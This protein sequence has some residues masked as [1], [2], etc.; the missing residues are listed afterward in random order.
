M[1]VADDNLM[2]RVRSDG[3]TF[4]MGIKEPQVPASAVLSNFPQDAL[5]NPFELA[6]EW[7]P[8]NATITE[9]V[10]TAP[11][12]ITAVLFDYGTSG[13]ASVIWPGST[14]ANE[15][16]F[17]NNNLA[18]AV[19]V[20]SVLAAPTSTT[21]GEIA[22]DS[23]ATGPAWITLATPETVE[24][25]QVYLIG[26]AGSEYVAIEAVQSNAGATL[27]RVSTVHTHAPG[28]TLTGEAAYRML[29]PNGAAAGNTLSDG[30]IQLGVSGAGQPIQFVGDVVVKFYMHDHAFAGQC[31][32]RNPVDGGNNPGT[33]GYPQLATAT[34]NSILFNPIEYNG[35]PDPDVQPIEWAT[36]AGDGTITGYT[37][38]WSGATQN[39]NMIVLASIVIPAAGTY[40][41]SFRHDDGMY[42]GMDGDYVVLSGP[43]NC[44]APFPTVSA[45]NGYP[46]VGASNVSN[47]NV[48]TWDIQFNAAGVY[49]IE[50]DYCQWENEQELGIFINGQTV[51]PGGSSTPQYGMY[52]FRQAY[53]SLMGNRQIQPTDVVH[54]IL[55]TNLPGLIES[56]VVTFNIDPVAEDFTTNALQWGITGADILAA[57][58]WEDLSIPVQALTRIGTGEVA[59]VEVTVG[60]TDYVQSSTSV[61]FTGGGGTGA[62]GTPIVDPATGAV[63]GVN[64]TNAGE[65]YT[66]PPVVEITG[67]GTG[68]VAIA[69]ISA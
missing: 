37:Q 30:Y 6:S 63:T 56:I 39:Y 57:N 22:Y 1:Y 59:S 20:A 41:V 24:Q 68:A 15:T 47:D 62:T 52:T 4:K 43:Q 5:I 65:N 55:Q 2:L 51:T 60:G 28:A 10:R 23:G 67:A 64:I 36:L 3:T 14:N 34:G 16:L 46:L 54:L 11:T 9:E 8:I 12:A 18:N 50:I 32:L 42:W 19:F 35:T 40:P 48:D 17:L 38:P 69:T 53:S 45:L 33:G 49:D 7:T 58:T 44:P 13:Q 25:G 21:I 29:F 27:I 26:G 61:A 66:S 31:E